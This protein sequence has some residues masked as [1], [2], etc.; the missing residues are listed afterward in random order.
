MQT[1]SIII[2]FHNE[3]NNIVKV[4]QQVVDFLDLLSDDKKEIIF[5]NDGSTDKSSKQVDKMIKNKSYVKV[6]NHKKKMGIGTCLK[7]GYKMAKMENVCA[8]PGDGQFDVNELRAFRKVPSQTVVSFFRSKNMQYSFLRKLLTKVNKGLNKILFGI[9]V[10]D[11]NWVK[12]YKTSEI[13]SLNLKSKSSYVESEIIYRLKNKNCKII[14]SPSHYLSRKFSYSKSVTI[15]SLKTVGKD[16]ISL[17]FNR[18]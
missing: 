6:V 8:V 16:I 13:K 11:I 1:W 14:Q 17:F 15:S 10:Q 4:C 3:E 18:N 7:T 2:F 9:D 12:I 5:V